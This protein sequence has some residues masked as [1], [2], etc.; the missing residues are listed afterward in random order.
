MTSKVYRKRNVFCT[1]GYVNTVGQS[2]RKER[3]K[4]IKKIKMSEMINEKRKY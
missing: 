1:I 3:K 2:K 4:I